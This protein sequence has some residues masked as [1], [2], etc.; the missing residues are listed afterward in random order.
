[1]ACASLIS[2]AFFCSF[3]LG[4]RLFNMGRK[5]FLHKAQAGDALRA[6]RTLEVHAECVDQTLQ[7]YKDGQVISSLAEA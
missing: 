1:M 4:V 5:W 7:V 6:A 2:S 3:K